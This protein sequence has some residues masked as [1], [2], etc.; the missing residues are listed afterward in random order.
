MKIIFKER[1]NNEYTATLL[2]YTWLL[3]LYRNHPDMLNINWKQPH[4]WKFIILF[5]RPY[6]CPVEILISY[7]LHLV[8]W[9][10]FHSFALKV[11]KTAICAAI[12]QVFSVFQGIIS[13]VFSSLYMSGIKIYVRNASS[14]SSINQ[15]GNKYQCTA[16]SISETMC[17]ISSLHSPLEMRT[18]G[19][20]ILLF[21]F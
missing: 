6:D 3:N 4:F 1:N 5:E 15:K 12:V 19:H 11:F 13:F 21:L 8:I 2:T 9:T 16:G 14:I 17:N 18:L 7:N 20:I 10:W